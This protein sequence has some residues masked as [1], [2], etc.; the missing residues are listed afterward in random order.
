MFHVLIQ[1]VVTSRI[2]LLNS[3]NTGRYQFL[4]WNKFE[5]F[6]LEID[7]QTR[8]YEWNVD[9]ILNLDGNIELDSQELKFVDGAKGF[10]YCLFICTYLCQLKT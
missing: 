5:R 10:L 4:P 2:S 6:L 8:L 3:D 7:L 9:I 1:E